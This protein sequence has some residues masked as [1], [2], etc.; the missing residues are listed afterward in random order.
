MNE[1]ETQQPL[2]VVSDLN[3]EL[4][5]NIDDIVTVVLHGDDNE[6]TGIMMNPRKLWVGLLDYGRTFIADECSI[7]TI[8]P[9]IRGRTL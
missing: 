6:Y 1:K 8:T 4:G 7:K 2:G 9:A 5:F 3:N